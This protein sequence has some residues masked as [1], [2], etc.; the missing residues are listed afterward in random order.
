MRKKL[1]IFGFG[2]SAV[3]LADLCKRNGDWDVTG[4][5]RRPDS[6]EDSQHQVINFDLSSITESLKGTT[7]VLVSTP[8][9]AQNQDPTF[10]QFASVIGENLSS[11]K[12]LGYL[13][14]TGVYGNY[15]GQWIDESAETEPVRES[16]RLR[17][18]IEQQWL[19]FGLEHNIPAHVFRLA[20]IYGPNRNCLSDLKANKARPIYKKDHVFNH[21]HVTDIGQVLY[22]SMINPLQGEVYNVCDDEPTGYPEVIEYGAQLLNMQPPERI[23]FETADISPRMREFYNSSKRI[24]NDK[25][26]KLLGKELTYPTYRQGLQACL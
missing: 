24:R 8:T 21:I 5:S 17:V 18:T 9:D 20:G 15:D 12:W 16:G 7:H 26:K 4:T 25:I 10:A 14:T 23:D 6:F 1:L 22:A 19:K 13:S 11:I 3:E 2:F